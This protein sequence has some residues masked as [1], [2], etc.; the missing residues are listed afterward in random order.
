LTKTVSSSSLRIIGGIWRG[1]K[2]SFAE[3]PQV[4]PSPSRVRETLFNWLQGEIAGKSCLELFS[5]SGILSFE[6]LSRGAGQV[7]LVDQEAE[8]CRQQRNSFQQLNVSPDLFSIYCSS[9]EKYLEA[10]SSHPFDVIFMDPPFLMA[11][12]QPLVK[13]II[14]NQW[15]QRDGL[16]Y[17]ESG[18][19]LGQDKKFADLPIIKQKQAGQV[20]STL[21][22]NEH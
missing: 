2:V 5:G 18:I 21:M 20:H 19:K 13:T 7:V 12:Y 10:P 1:S 16:I 6:A 4:R 8:V 9:A 14:D 15:L 11:D 22:R 3:L 17:I